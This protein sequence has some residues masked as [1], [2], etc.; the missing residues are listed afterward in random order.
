VQKAGGVWVALVSRTGRAVMKFFTT[1]VCYV[2]SCGQS[3]TYQR[4]N[5]M[6]SRLMSS[7]PALISSLLWGNCNE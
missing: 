7:P 1:E 4:M 3:L 6:S 2:A 5:G